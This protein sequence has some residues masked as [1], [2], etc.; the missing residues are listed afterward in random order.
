MPENRHDK[1]LVAAA[2]TLA[3]YCNKL[4]NAI[5]QKTDEPGDN[6]VI[7]EYDRFVSELSKSF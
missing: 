7:Q 6:T 4:A 3:S 1:E 2:L 5:A